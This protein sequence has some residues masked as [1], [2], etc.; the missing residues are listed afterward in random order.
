MTRTA[1]FR[2]PVPTTVKRSRSRCC[3]PPRSSR[4]R[5]AVSCGSCIEIKTI[6]S[7][8]KFEAGSTG[9]EVL[10]FGSHIPGNGEMVSERTTHE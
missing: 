10:A 1:T 6:G 7:A 5:P 3:M 4:K 9:L 8:R 2:T